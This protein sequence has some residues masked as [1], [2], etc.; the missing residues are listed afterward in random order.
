MHV[1]VLLV[2]VEGG[3]ACECCCMHACIFMLVYV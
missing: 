2:C 3:T 1:A